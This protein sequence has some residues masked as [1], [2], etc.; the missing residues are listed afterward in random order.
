MEYTALVILAALAQYLF[1][2]IRVGSGRVKYGVDA[3]RIA[4]NDTWERLFRVQQNTLE[5][6]IV[7]I[8][9]A[10]IFGLYASG[11]WV[12]LPALV[13]LVGRQL[14]FHEY[15]NDPKSR[16]TGMGLTL[17]A[18]AALVVGAVVGLVLKLV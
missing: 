13:F 3:P 18:N 6:L 11:T 9:A 15:V 2:T 7:F 14:Y 1:F 12:L 10:V 5:Q 16:V 8:P 17:L 4:G